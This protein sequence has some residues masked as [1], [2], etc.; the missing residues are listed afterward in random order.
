MEFTK[1]QVKML[2]CF[3]L[4]GGM[5]LAGCSTDDSIDV[6]DV[7]TTI[8]VNLNDFTV[9]LGGSEEIT[10]KDLLKLKDDD[11]IQFIMEDDNGKYITIDNKRIAITEGEKGDYIFYKKG[12]DV[13]PGK[14]H[15]DAI[16]INGS[17]DNNINPKIGPSQKPAGLDYL[18]VGDEIPNSAGTMKVR[19]N[20]FDYSTDKPEDVVSLE[21]AGVD[22]QM[23]LNLE[24]NSNLQGFLKKFNQFD[25]EF[26]KYME[27]ESATFGTLVGN[28][29]KLGQLNTSQKYTTT[30]KI[31]QLKFMN[32]DTT[33]KLAIEGD[34]IN[35]LGDVN[36]T[37]S[38]DNLVKGSGDIT[39]MRIM[40]KVNIGTVKL[41]SAT[42]KFNPNIDIKDSEFK[43]DD[44]PDFLD[45]PQVSISLNDP[46]LTLNINSNVD[47]DAAIDGTLTSYFSD[48]TQKTVEVKNINVPRNKN[49]KILICR[50]PKAEPYEDYTQVVV[51]SNL[52]DLIE[53]IP[54]KIK[55]HADV[56]VDKEKTGTILLGH[57][58]QIS[59]A[60]DFKA[61]LSMQENSVI[62]YDDKVDGF[63]EDIVD[64]DI[65]FI[66]EANLVI[67]GKVTN[68]TP[69]K[70]KIEP[71]A[72]DNSKEP[73]ELPSIKLESDQVIASN[74]SGKEPTEL[75]ITLTK[76]ADVNLKD[77]NFD[78]IKFK[79]IATS[80]DVTTLNKDKH[81]IKIEDLKVSINSKISI[82]TDSK[83]DKK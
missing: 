6:G 11:C 20:A 31:K 42:G 35:M 25:I 27:P 29:L 67:T 19:L 74:L 17:A 1:L 79:V 65:D 63:H 64:N 37:V 33:N 30:V 21:S 75:K 41:T 4:A 58:Y 43:I 26:P 77:I 47:L 71:V 3:L 45:D 9:P 53:R 28:V 16:S 7:D 18:N 23:T 34:K 13:D 55:F 36:V 50:Q 32:V 73:K 5:M 22:G 14:P 54:D 8:G 10:I 76:P 48:G 57:N 59:T 40:S 60:Y 61:P 2:S 62:V 82:D 66:G 83:K 12:D 51:V 81:S 24:F 15:V 46:Q 69:L 38:Y 70:L 56:C 44:V 72:I 52:S 78:G 80:V 49:S 68:K 39:D